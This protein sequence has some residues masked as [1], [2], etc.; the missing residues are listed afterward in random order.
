MIFTYQEIKEI[1]R[2]KKY[3]FYEKI[4]DMNIIGVRSKDKQ[5][6]KFDDFIC[7]LYLDEFNNEIMKIYLATTDPGLYWLQN[8]GNTKG[9]AI[10]KPGQYL[11]GWKVGLHRGE[12][13]ALV[14]NKPMTVYRDYNRDVFFDII[15]GSEE[16]GIFG[17]NL[18]HAGEDSQIV[19]KWSAGCQVFKKLNDFNEVMKLVDKQIE[20]GLGEV[21]SYT[22]LTE[23]DFENT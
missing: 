1:M 21:F 17:I 16:T 9:T 12:Y 13:R 19:D 18:H 3:K 2:K 20:N 6:N 10:L 8:P 23:E 4:Y 14:Q 22:L 5:P 11:S 15:P 7:V